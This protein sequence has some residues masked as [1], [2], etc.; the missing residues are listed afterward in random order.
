V[1]TALGGIAGAGLA[2]A[3]VQT[4]GKGLLHPGTAPTLTAAIATILGAA[5][6]VLIA[7]RTGLP[8]STTHA[9]VGALVGVAVL[10]YGMH[11]VA[12]HALV[13]KVALPLAA[14]PLVAIAAT[15]AL[16]RGATA[17]VGPADCVCADIVPERL[18]LSHLHWLTSGATSFA[19]GMN[20]APKMVA[21][22]LAALAISGSVRASSPALFAWIAAGMVAGSLIAGRRVTHVLAERVTPL[23]HREGFVANGVTAALVVAGAVLG[24][25]MS[26][27]HVASSAIIG[28]GAQRKPGLLNR[29]TVREMVLAWLLTLPAAALLGIA[30]Y[31]ALRLAGR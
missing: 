7:T 13:Q 30:A 18:T 19:R 31:E 29:K 15:V 27:T 28:V 4:F 2:G 10:A 16:V 3:M 23:D 5:A 6:W 25:P 24:W 12:W 14:S 22:A 26:T 20:D 9:I 17:L 1:F 21:L 8:V 11:A